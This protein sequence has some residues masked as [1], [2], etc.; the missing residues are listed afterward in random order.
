MH[1]SSTCAAVFQLAGR[2]G[3]AM[4]SSAGAPEPAVDR[5]REKRRVRAAIG[6]VE[7][8]RSQL[9]GHPCARRHCWVFV[10]R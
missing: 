1:F 5:K 4:I 10:G 3:V 8:P 7:L 9:I 6:A 2:D